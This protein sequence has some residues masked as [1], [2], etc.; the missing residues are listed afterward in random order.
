[1]CHE[2]KFAAQLLRQHSKDGDPMLL[3]RSRASALTPLRLCT[4]GALSRL[5]APKMLQRG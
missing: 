2:A 4:L 1:M 3:G 5:L